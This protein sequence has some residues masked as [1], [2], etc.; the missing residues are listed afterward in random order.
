VEGSWLFLFGGPFHV[1]VP[2]Y[3]VDRLTVDQNVP[4]IIKAIDNVKET[5]PTEYIIIIII[6]IIIY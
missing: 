3:P 5:F 2:Y 1:Y 6:I 4:L